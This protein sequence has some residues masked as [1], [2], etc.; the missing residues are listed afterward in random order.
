VTPRRTAAWPFGPV[1]L[2]FGVKRN[3]TGI[4]EWRGEALAS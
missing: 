1:S 4:I 2:F 3:A